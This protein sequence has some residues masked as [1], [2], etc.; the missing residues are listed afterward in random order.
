MLLKNCACHRFKLSDD[1]VPMS[2]LRSLP[3]LH[4]HRVCVDGRRAA[5]W[6]RRSCLDLTFCPRSE[7]CALR[8]CTAVEVAMFASDILRLPRVNVPYLLLKDCTCHG[9]K[10][11]KFRACRVKGSVEYTSRS[12]AAM[13]R[14]CEM[15]HEAVI[16]FP[17]LSTT[18][19]PPGVWGS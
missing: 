16:C 4:V 18:A 7:I 10:L 13:L 9:L 8:L 2:S 17:W 14:Q 19:L 12:P 3:C 15:E 11:L 6:N 1:E 5:L